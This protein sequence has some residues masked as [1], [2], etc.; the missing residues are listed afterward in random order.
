M[1]S[2]DNVEDNTRFAKEAGGN[3]PIL[4][5]P[6]KVMIGAYGVGNARFQGLASRWTFYI[7]K[8]GLIKRIDKSV[9]PGSAG[10]DMA[11]AMT[12]LGFSEKS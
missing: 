6:D 2:G 8:D 10:A 4:S 1:V 12:E 11:K 7:G 3:F 5:D 9:S